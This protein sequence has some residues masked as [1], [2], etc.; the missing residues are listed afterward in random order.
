MI[1][2]NRKEAGEKLA[3]KLQSFKGKENTVVF[4]IPRGGVVVAKKVADKLKLPF[5][6]IVVKKIGAPSNPELAI[7]AVG[8]KKTIYLDN[9]LCKVLGLSKA[10][11]KNLSDKKEQ[12]RLE[13][14]SV[15]RGN[16]QQVNVCG[17]III[18]IDDGIAT[19]A[20]VLCALEC[21]KREGAKKVILAVP[22]IA[23]ETFDSIQ[24]DFDK[25]VVLS[26][27]DNFY[28]VGQFY[29]E[30]PQVEDEEVIKILRG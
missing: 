11:I 10:Q 7:G 22:V 17:K 13:R 5:D 20:T 16:R 2:K 4:G 6:I 23:K 12:E 15:L 3:R 19:G 8:P 9:K 25:S 21:F 29:Q 28:A 24:K 30:F 1:F 18:L 27:E 14:E 26:I